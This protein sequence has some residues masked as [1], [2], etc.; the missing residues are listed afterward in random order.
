MRRVLSLL[1]LVMWPAVALAAPL[2][3]PHRVE[4]PAYGQILYDY[5][6]QQYFAALTTTLV[7]LDSNA[8]PTQRDRARVMLGVLYLAYDMPQ[9]AEALFDALL[10]EDIDPSLSTRIWIHLAELYYRRARPAQALALL[11]QR[12]TQ[13]PD[14]L[15]EHYHALRTRILMRLGRYDETLAALAQLDAG[16]RLNAYL[17]YNLAVSRI[18]AGQGEAGLLSLR[19]LTALP[20]GDAEINAIKDRALLALG[21]HHLRQGE[22]QQAAYYMGFA[23]L[24]GPYA[25]LSLLLHARAALDQGAPA[26]ALGSLQQLVARPMQYEPVQEGALLLPGVY[27]DLGDYAAA[28]QGY[29]NA[30]EGYT[31]HYRYLGTLSEQIRAGDWFTELLGE[32]PWSTAMDPLPPLVPERA[33]SFVSFRA[34][35]ASHAF[36]SAWRNYHELLRQ[37]RLLARWRAALPAMEQLLA[38]HETRHQERV[39][40]AHAL[41]AEVDAA[42]LDQQLQHLFERLDAAVLDN[43]WRALG[44]EQETRLLA[45]LT[46]ARAL[47]EKWGDRVRPN[48]REK[49]AFYEGLL[50]W[51]LQDDQV[52]R[53][54]QH[55]KALNEAQRLLQDTDAL[56]GRVARAAT[57]DSGRLAQWRSA[58]TDL[59]R[60]VEELDARGEQLMQRQQD[61][62]ETLALEWIARER[63][64][65]NGLAAQ[66]WMALSDVQ[67]RA[68]R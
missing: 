48:V 64:R 8:L 52:P 15:R 56:R 18:N 33:D 68:A 24:D 32:V 54:W 4:D 1:L 63:P 38:A 25:E 39:P 57:D 45:A 22:P 29:R 43:D 10:T 27:E 19:E 36:H 44:D 9:D 53:Q 50:A 58:L 67:A 30:I 41:L 65:L 11:D 31:A 66:A 20:P 23:R 6:Q 14:D 60:T 40:Q 2:H 3:A 49:L 61:A 46:E 7:A 42:R 37:R 35:F 55:R 26:R 5:F 21:V 59:T 17:K 16:S 62:I 13:V 47:A 51:D 28:E 12:V 34:L